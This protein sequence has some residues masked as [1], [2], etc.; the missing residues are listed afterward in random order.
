M[1][2][3]GAPPDG[4]ERGAPRLRTTRPRAAPRA[5]PKWR[6][7]PLPRSGGPERLT[8]NGTGGSS[9]ASSTMRQRAPAFKPAPRPAAPPSRPAPPLSR[10]ARAPQAPPPPSAP[11]P[12][13]RAPLPD[14]RPGPKGS[15]HDAGDPYQL[16][17]ARDLL[18]PHARR[19]VRDRGQGERYTTL[20]TLIS[21]RPLAICSRPHARRCRVRDRGQGER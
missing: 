20:A 1:T 17:S 21:S 2:D 18:R 19:W 10:P 11:F 14:A 16:P 5:E 15:V 13:A 7:A 9:F 6:N 3:F 8:N 4:S 12:S